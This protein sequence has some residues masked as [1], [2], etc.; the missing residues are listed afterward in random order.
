MEMVLK[1]RI[2]HA[3]VETT[4]FHS[5]RVLSSLIRRFKDPAFDELQSNKELLPR[6]I[7]LLMISFEDF[8]ISEAA[9]HC[10]YQIE[11][12]G[13]REVIQEMLEG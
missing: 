4:S 1:G 8:S 9:M 12:Y 11:F 3:F 6:I 10:L 2:I 7:N 13:K 5:I